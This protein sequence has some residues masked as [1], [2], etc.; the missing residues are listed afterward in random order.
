MDHKVG[1]FAD[2]LPPT[3]TSDQEATDRLRL[4][5]CIMWSRTRN[6]PRNAAVTRVWPSLPASPTVRSR[7]LNPTE[8]KLPPAALSTTEGNSHAAWPSQAHQ[9]GPSSDA[10][11]EPVSSP[12]VDL[13]L[14]P[15]PVCPP[16]LRQKHTNQEVASIFKPSCPFSFI[17]SKL[18]EENVFSWKFLGLTREFTD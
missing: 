14:C 1:V 4:T 13:E 2:C 7:P 9:F 17:T 16:A 15:S 10:V 5:S 6:L 3:V 18:E 8:G 12:V 11:S